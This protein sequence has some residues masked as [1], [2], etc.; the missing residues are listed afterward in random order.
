MIDQEGLSSQLKER[1]VGIT[2]FK[3]LSV[4]PDLSELKKIIGESVENLNPYCNEERGTS[5]IDFWLRKDDQKITTKVNFWFGTPRES[6]SGKY[7]YI[8]KFGMSTIYLTEEELDTKDF[9]VEGF[10]GKPYTSFDKD[11]CRQLYNGE[12]ELTN[13]LRAWLVIPKSRLCRLDNPDNILKGDFTELKAFQS[14]NHVVCA[15]GIKDSKY[16]SVYN[17]ENGFLSNMITQ[18]VGDK[19]E[20]IKRTDYSRIAK[21]IGK[22]NYYEIDFGTSPYTWTK[23]TKNLETTP[24]NNGVSATTADTLPF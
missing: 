17:K 15:L 22:D 16:Y 8:D 20:T 2:D 21:A 5:R 4:N 1:F 10:D 6:N 19:Y 13:F 9:T 12:A 23:Y 3:V 18:K 11:S 24:S 7:R 14:K